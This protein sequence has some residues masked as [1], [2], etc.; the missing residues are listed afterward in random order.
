MNSRLLLSAG[1]SP[2]TPL[3]TKIYLKHSISK[4]W[5]YAGRLSTRSMNKTA[6]ECPDYVAYIRFKVNPVLRN[7]SNF[8]A[9]L[10]SSRALRSASGDHDHLETRVKPAMRRT[11]G[12]G[13]LFPLKCYESPLFGGTTAANNQELT[14][15]ISEPIN[16]QE[17]SAST[18]FSQVIDRH[19]SST[20]LQR[21]SEDADINC[22]SSPSEFNPDPFDDVIAATKVS[23]GRDVPH[24]PMQSCK[25][26]Y[27]L[28]D[29]AKSTLSTSDELSGNASAL[30]LFTRLS[31]TP[32]TLTYTPHTSM[33]SDISANMPHAP[34][35]SSKPVF[36][37]GL[38]L[39]LA[40][41]KLR[42]TPSVSDGQDVGER[43][44]QRRGGGNE[45]RAREFTGR[46]I[47]TS[48]LLSGP[49]QDKRIS[50]KRRLFDVGHITLLDASFIAM[51][52]PIQTSRYT[53][54]HPLLQ[55]IHDQVR[56][57]TSDGP[58][59]PV[60]ITLKSLIERHRRSRSD[61]TS[62]S[63]S[64]GLPHPKDLASLRE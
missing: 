25:K 62:L 57:S 23:E 35:P 22:T 16:G 52:Y 44:E 53:P 59:V 18:S 55:S 64:P 60:P 41:S 47:S 61:L 34:S 39:P 24:I 11:P 27:Y 5:L 48:E 4:R 19:A 8:Y 58:E 36:Q 43:V 46:R 31:N 32:R 56:T 33:P 29:G 10:A 45:R 63:D 1:H 40:P 30:P 12:D 26:S 15:T 28:P 7:H 37:N 3:Q 14:I 51:A 42:N 6:V 2:H 38:T 13:V 50:D 9:P 54:V 20:K 17:V 49:H 21:S